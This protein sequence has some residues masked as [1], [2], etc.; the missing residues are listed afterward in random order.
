MASL[1]GLDERAL[2]VVGRGAAWDSQDAVGARRRR[3]RRHFYFSIGDDDDRDDDRDDVDGD[4]DYVGRSDNALVLC[5]SIS[6]ETVSAY[7]FLAFFLPLV[8]AVRSGLSFALS[9]RD[10]EKPKKKNGK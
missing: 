10:R 5:R 9:K 6:I 8:F 7:F 3:R 4:V 2:D 1:G